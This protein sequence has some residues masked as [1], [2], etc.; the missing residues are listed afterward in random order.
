M[1]TRSEFEELLASLE[2][3]R[4]PTSEIEL[5][6]KRHKILLDLFNKLVSTV[7]DAQ[8]TRGGEFTSLEIVKICAC[9]LGHILGSAADEEDDIPKIL[10]SLAYP[11]LMTGLIAYEAKH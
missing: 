9:F 10:E 5:I 6:L 3:G 11:I 8:E 1:Q 2:E 4:G 7:T